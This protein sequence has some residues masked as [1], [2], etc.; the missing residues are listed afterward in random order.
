MIV[1]NNIIFSECHSPIMIIMFVKKT[2][3]CDLI[4]MFINVE[5]QYCHLFSVAQIWIKAD[6]EDPILSQDKFGECNCNCGWPS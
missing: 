2:V 1:I 4:L 3:H 6:A 5:Y